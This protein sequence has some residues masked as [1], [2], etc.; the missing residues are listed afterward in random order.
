L[1]IG[2]STDGKIKET[3]TDAQTA[4]DT[5][6]ASKDDTD[7]K[8]VP[9]E[10]S[11][12][13]NIPKSVEREVKKLSPEAK[14]AYDKAI[15][16]LKSGDTRGLNDHALTGDRAGQRAVDIKGIGKGKGQGRIVYKKNS[17]G[18]I[19]IIKVLTKHDY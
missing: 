15:E 17:D 1:N 11:N 18:S 3:T 14:R 8:S 10:S 6:D 2:T 13:I 7:S 5:P 9:K 12:T 16:G 4:S 19:E